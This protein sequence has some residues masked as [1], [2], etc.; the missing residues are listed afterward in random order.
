VYQRRIIEQGEA[1]TLAEFLRD[2]WL[3][4]DRRV[5]IVRT[6]MIHSSFVIR[7]ATISDQMAKQ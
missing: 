7:A 4:N 5:V 3:Q 1:A 6:R 2:K